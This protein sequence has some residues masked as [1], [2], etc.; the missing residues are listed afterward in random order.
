MKIINIECVG[1]DWGGN[2]LVFTVHIDKE[3]VD[4]KYI[5]DKLYTLN[6]QS[7]FKWDYE[8]SYDNMD[9]NGLFFSTLFIDKGNLT[10]KIED[11]KVIITDNFICELILS[12]CASL[13]E[14]LNDF[15]NNYRI[16]YQQLLWINIRG[17]YNY[18]DDVYEQFLD[19]EEINDDELKDL[20]DLANQDIS[21]KEFADKQGYEW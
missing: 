8:Y 21:L 9:Y 6:K 2:N 1:D 4:T 18:E 12:S 19:S 15:K 17:I 10:H 3:T 13:I 16:K 11:D 14:D 20:E 5:D 7:D